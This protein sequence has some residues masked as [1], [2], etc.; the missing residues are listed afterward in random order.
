MEQPFS[1][2]PRKSKQRK[3]PPPLDTWI[4][5]RQ[6]W[7]HSQYL[8]AET[9]NRDKYWM[10]QQRLKIN[11]MYLMQKTFRW[12][13]SLSPLQWVLDYCLQKNDIK[14]QELSA[15]FRTSGGESR[16]QGS[17]SGVIK[18]N[19]LSEHSWC[20]WELILFLGTRSL[21]C[22]GIADCS[23]CCSYASVSSSLKKN[24]YK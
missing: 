8:S 3:C 14:H 17:L 5:Y 20:F 24:I 13:L 15:Q 23:S 6:M 2:S 12:T 9:L 1:P 19:A 4:P 16:I 11:P 21:Q 7:G 22:L 10:F 18:I